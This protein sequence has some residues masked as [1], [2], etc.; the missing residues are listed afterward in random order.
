MASKI[1]KTAGIL[2]LIAAVLF[3]QLP[4]STA[5]AERADFQTDGDV[6]IKYTG[7]DKEVTIPDGISVIG[8][9][10]F[11]ENETVEKVIIPEG[12]TQ[13]RAHAFYG[14][15]SLQEAEVSDSVERIGNAAFAECDQL[16]KVTLGSGVR[17]MGSGVFSGCPLL[18]DI[19]L[20]EEHAYLSVENGA[21]M[22]AGHTRLYEVLNGSDLSV[23]DMPDTIETIDK[24]A[25]WGC[26]HI[27]YVNLSDSLTEIP[28]YAFSNCRGLS[29]ITIPYS[30]TGIDAKAFENCSNLEA[31]EIP[32]TVRSIHETAFD[33]CGKLKIKAAAGSIAEQ[34]AQAHEVDA[35][36][37]TEYEE[38]R[39]TVLKQEQPQESDQESDEGSE[40]T[41]PAQEE[42]ISP[43]PEIP[44]DTDTTGEENDI[45]DADFMG[46]TVIVSGQA[47][48]FID[49]SRQSVYSGEPEDTAAPQANPAGGQEELQE[50]SPDEQGTAAKKGL[51]IPKYTVVDGNTIANQAYYGQSALTE[52]EIDNGIEQIG[53]FAFARSALGKINIPEGVTDIGY[54]A[55]YHCD[56]LVEVTIPQTVTDIEPYAFAHTPWLSSWEHETGED[57]LIVGDGILLAYRGSS[58][59][60]TIPDG[61]KKIAAGCFR[62]HTGIVSV[63]I[64]DSVTEIGEEAFYGCTN[65][66]SVQGADGVVKIAD[67]AFAGCPISNVPIHENVEWIGARA[68]DMDGT[69]RESSNNSVWFYGNAATQLP[70]AGYEASATRYYRA[71]NR[72][73]CFNGISVAVVPDRTTVLDGTVLDPAVSGFRGY[74][75]TPGTDQENGTESMIILK[76]TLPEADAQQMEWPQMLQIGN[77]SYPVSE[78]AQDALSYYENAVSDGNT[79][80]DEQQTENDR[81][82]T[83]DLELSLRSVFLTHPELASARLSGNT[84]MIRITVA[85]DLTASQLIRDKY[86]ALYGKNE[87]LH[88]QGFNIT[89]DASYGIPITVFGTNELALTLP[90]PDEMQNSRVYVLCLDANGQL[91]VADSEQ[92][93]SEDVP[94]ITLHAGHLS[95]YAFMWIDG[96]DNADNTSGR[97]DDSPDTGDMFEP[98]YVL[99]TGMAALSAVLIL[100]KK[101]KHRRKHAT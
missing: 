25:F 90:L 64:P 79:I 84:E 97:L 89:A 96:G 61:V 45:Q 86:E 15:S 28:A 41:T 27:N 14:C 66:Y 43:T 38:I 83:D 42:N 5:S 35:I 53:D 47:V 67:R 39:D 80:A 23:Y 62:G 30:V 98:R 88:F 24:Y 3:S 52:Y 75:C 26:D 57:F 92:M 101:P 51:S 2:L 31:V 10:A 36:S 37:Q 13:I 76:C 100:W 59:K 40:E 1:R 65:L 95:P 77:N 72:G 29:A 91:E 54:G 11:W 73:L 85:D 8:E 9:E 58:S 12:V 18:S 87:E 70:K 19:G 56:D 74:I 68:F 48:V 22:N 32:E 78:V 69:V 16:Q 7:N 82:G 6:L 99:C 94:C 20:D 50:T 33:G 21:I 71:D 60:I 93:M 34:F 49:R 44:Q 81:T 46:Q 17:E 4:G 55:F 63:T